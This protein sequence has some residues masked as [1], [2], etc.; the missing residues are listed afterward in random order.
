MLMYRDIQEDSRS[1]RRRVNVAR[2]LVSQLYDK[3]TSGQI[4]F[5]TFKEE[6]L[7]IADG[8][9]APDMYGTGFFSQFRDH[10]DNMHLLFDLYD[11]G[12][13]LRVELFLELKIWLRTGDWS[14]DMY[15]YP[16]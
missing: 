10:K 2:K 3:Y 4:S 14:N 16:F 7:Q 13:F 6:T 12:E 9:E 1:Y 15:D 8:L 11:S 5:D